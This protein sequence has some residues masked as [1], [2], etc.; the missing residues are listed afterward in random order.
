MM[1]TISKT[2][3]ARPGSPW[4]RTRARAA[5]GVMPLVHSRH[6]VSPSASTSTTGRPAAPRSNLHPERSRVA[7]HAIAASPVIVTCTLRPRGGVGGGQREGQRPQ[8][9]VQRRH[10]ELT[11]GQ[12]RPAGRIPHLLLVGPVLGELPSRVQPHR[13]GVQPG[14]RHRRGVRLRVLLLPHSGDLPAGEGKQLHQLPGAQA[15]CRCHPLLVDP[16]AEDRQRLAVIPKRALLPVAHAGQ[17]PKVIVEHVGGDVLDRPPRTD[18]GA[19]PVT[20]TQPAKQLQERRPLPGEQAP[21]INPRP[22]LRQLDH[23]AS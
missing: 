14:P 7:T 22:D 2:W 16:S 11:T 8:E 6:I 20:H 12:P 3:L 1:E 17:A 23:R 13:R 15:T 10:Q 5:W 4:T 19:V 18:R 21:N 9:R